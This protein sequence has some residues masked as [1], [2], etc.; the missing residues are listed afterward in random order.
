MS[1]W[2]RVACLLLVAA[3][4]G[5]GL[6][7]RLAWLDVAPGLEHDEALILLGAGRIAEGKLTLTGDKVYEGP[8]LEYLIAAAWGVTGRSVAAARLVVGLFGI[9][10]ALLLWG[11]GAR[12]FSP[13]A[14][15][16]GGVL[17]LVSPWGV[18]AGRV[19]Y[20]CNLTPA[21][22]LLGFWLALGEG[23]LRLR[24]AAAGAAI[25]LAMHG[26]AYAGLALPA[27]LV[28]ARPGGRGRPRRL[29]AVALVAGGLLAA[30][31]PILVA[32]LREG[33]PSLTVFLG[34]E[35][36]LAGTGGA[37]F[38]RT[39][40]PRWV[41]F[42]GTAFGALRGDG[43]W[44]DFPRLAWPARLWLT[45]LVAL[46]GAIWILEL[47]LRRR[48]RGALIWL[49]W[50]VPATVVL[51]LITKHRAGNLFLGFA[52]ASIPHYLDLHAPLL[53][54]AAGVVP[55]RLLE[56][57]STGR[58]RGVALLITA[59]LLVSNVWFSG[60][61]LLPRIREFGDVGRWRRGIQEACA[62]I[63]EQQVDRLFVS[64]VF[65]GGY[66]QARF[67]LPDLP[68]TPVLHPPTGACRDGEPLPARAAYLVPVE[69]WA[70]PPP[71]LEPAFQVP[72]E[73]PFWRV[74]LY[75]T[76]HLLLVARWFPQG[77]R[78]PR[79]VR[80]RWSATGGEIRVQG[81]DAG[82]SLQG[83]LEKRRDRFGAL[84]F[85]GSAEVRPTERHAGELERIQPPLAAIALEGAR[86]GDGA[87]LRVEIIRTRP[88]RLRIRAGGSEWTG[89]LEVE[90]LELW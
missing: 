55:A 33:F 71:G 74:Y 35:R 90:R 42:L 4:A 27:C 68:I 2:W 81:D 63:A 64:Y 69:P 43:A 57:A 23:W 29:A 25:G 3:V 60:W 37:G 66:P 13:L 40:V 46:G 77:E 54:L 22:T 18:M 6:Y 49:S 47:G 59:W 84:P 76:P 15:V 34:S 1:R 80:I 67:L 12:I 82:A 10:T 53:L 56:A 17:F 19:I 45:P 21:L 72:Q 89:E 8:L 73:T 79:R 83:S 48:R 28:A 70:A 30:Y 58:R 14:G 51:P 52:P 88:P 41:G 20:E 75:D 36:H 5:V 50:V 38:L 87:P 16:L 26:H 9:A 65:E 11:I 7:L 44:V 39:L 85:S 32:N 78:S 31:S 61:V 86:S 62:W 24:L